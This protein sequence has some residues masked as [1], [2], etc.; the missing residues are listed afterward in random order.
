[1]APSTGKLWS[2]LA[3]ALV[4][5]SMMTPAYASNER[6]PV[7]VS[8]TR[9][10]Q[11]GNDHSFWS[12]ISGDGRYV[13]FWSY[14]SNLVRGD[15]NGDDIFVTDRLRGRTERVNVSST[16]QEANHSNTE[17]PGI[18]LDGRFVVF[19]SYASNLVPRDT[20]SE[21]DVF[22]RDLHTDSTTR[23]SVTSDGTEATGGFSAGGRISAD[24]RFITFIS[25]A[26]NLVVGDTNG[27]NDVFVHDRATKKTTRVSVD[28]AGGQQNYAAFSADISHDG[29]FVAFTSTLLVWSPL[30]PGTL[31]GVFLYDRWT[32]RTTVISDKEPTANGHVDL[33]AHGSLVAF[34]SGADGVVS[35]D[36]DGLS[37]V[38]LYSRRNRVTTHVSSGLGDD[39]PP[40]YRPAISAEGRCL[41]FSTSDG[42]LAEGDSADMFAYNV[43]TRKTRLVSAS[44]DTIVGVQP[45]LSGDGR[46]LSFHTP[47]PLVRADINSGRL[48]CVR[49]RP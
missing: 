42:I 12:S 46:T 14:A 25:A 20:N 39:W 43:R 28:S 18:S 3:V 31:A 38:F 29:R 21:H 6:R 45:A 40:A 41:V 1:M 37:D 34:S 47:R 26:S 22:V 49:Y 48:G 10:N 2:G 44:G 33:D 36:A 27:T 9:S 11:S 16:G 32:G 23:V 13:A 24:G 15:T 17:A 4:L 35:T 8:T 5:A 7:L 30:P 19:N